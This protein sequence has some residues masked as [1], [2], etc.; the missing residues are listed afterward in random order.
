MK[1]W[2]ISWKYLDNSGSG[3]LNTA[4]MNEAYARATLDLLASEITHKSYELHE[5]YV[6][7]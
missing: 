6:Q 3:V 2:I 1:I 4:Y 5:L 7:E